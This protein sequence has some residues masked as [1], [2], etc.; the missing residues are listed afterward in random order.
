MG[1]EEFVKSFPKPGPKRGYLYEVSHEWP[2]KVREAEDPLDAFE[3]LL[4]WDEQLS[5]QT[6]YVY[7]KL[8][9]L[10]DIE[11]PKFSDMMADDFYNSLSK[12]LGSDRAASEALLDL[13]IPGH[14]YVDG[15][16]RG[17][18]KMPTH[19]HVMYDDRVPNVVSIEGIPIE[20]IDW[21]NPR[22]F[23]ERLGLGKVK[24]RK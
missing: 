11:D 2:D 23:M 20:E 13:D 10:V 5:G 6:T 1:F 17:T 9:N 15:W 16:T 7:N 18:S 19:N 24:R 4:Q 3:H 14:V 22:A 12:Q 21:G 8:K